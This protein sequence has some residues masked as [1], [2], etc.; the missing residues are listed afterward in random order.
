MRQLAAGQ[1]GALAR[2]QLLM[3]E[4]VRKGHSPVF[5]LMIHDDTDRCRRQETIGMQ[6][7][8]GSRFENEYGFEKDG[9]FIAFQCRQAAVAAL[10]AEQHVNGADDHRM[11][12]GEELEVFMCQGMAT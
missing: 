9:A 3:K 12:A 2:A 1:Q 4:L 6:P 10:R 7:G 5:L 8:R 11:V